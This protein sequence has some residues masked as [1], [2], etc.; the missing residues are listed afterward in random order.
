M[1][2]SDTPKLAIF[3]TVSWLFIA[4]MAWHHGYNS[5]ECE[6]RGGIYAKHNMQMKCI[7]QKEKPNEDV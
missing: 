7:I 2:N 1:S 4:I 3:L 5:G 6:A